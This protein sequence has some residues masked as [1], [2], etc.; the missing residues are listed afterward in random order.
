MSCVT[1][2]VAPHFLSPATI[3]CSHQNAKPPATTLS[4]SSNS[5]IPH[6]GTAHRPPGLPLIRIPTRTCCRRCAVRAEL[7]SRTPALPHSVVRSCPLL[8]YT[9]SQSV[10]GRWAWS[11]VKMLID[12][13]YRLLASLYS[14]FFLPCIFVGSER[15]TSNVSIW[16]VVKFVSWHPVRLKISLLLPFLI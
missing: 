1:L 8:T 14:S 11:L 2:T 13:S 4:T 9:G 15:K 3:P 5:H 12:I 6:T 16:E 7:P 10:D